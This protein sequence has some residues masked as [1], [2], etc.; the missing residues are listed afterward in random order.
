M[1]IKY[2]LNI[3]YVKGAP[4]SEQILGWSRSVTT[5]ENT[6]SFIVSKVDNGAK[7]FVYTSNGISANY[8]NIGNITIKA[9]IGKR[10]YASVSYQDYGYANMNTSRGAIIY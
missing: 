9:D 1:S 5:T 6:T 3:G 10:I 7:V 4:Q 2:S 8:T